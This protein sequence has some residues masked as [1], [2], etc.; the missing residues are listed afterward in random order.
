MGFDNIARADNGD[1]LL[2]EIP[3]LQKTYEVECDGM[4]G[5]MH[6]SVERV[7]EMSREESALQFWSNIESDIL[8]TKTQ[9]RTRFYAL[10][11]CVKTK[12]IPDKVWESF[13]KCSAAH[14]KNALFL[15]AIPETWQE[16]F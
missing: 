5:R 13:S 16:C 11:S 12:N 15:P 4:D 7:W 14:P 9:L 3:S 6:Q 2:F 1:V 10:Q 8:K